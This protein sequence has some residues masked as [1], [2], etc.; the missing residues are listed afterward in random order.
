[1]EVVGHVLRT[2]GN[3]MMIE[4]GKLSPGTYTC[5]LSCLRTKDIDLTY[6][7]QFLTPDSQIRTS[8]SKKTSFHFRFVMYYFFALCNNCKSFEMSTIRSNPKCSKIVG[9]SS[10]IFGNIRKW[11]GRFWKSR[12]WRDKNLTHL[13]HKKLAGIGTC[14]EKRKQDV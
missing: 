3:S 8:C 2:C 12:S 11:L 4:P 7:G 9:I 5:Q 14:K 6:R 10:D 1:M 13:T